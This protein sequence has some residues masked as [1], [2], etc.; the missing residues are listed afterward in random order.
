MTATVDGLTL[1]FDDPHL[2]PTAKAA[3]TAQQR[4][5]VRLTGP[6][7]KRAATVFLGGDHRLYDGVRTVLSPGSMTVVLSHTGLSDLAR[8]IALGRLRGHRVDV[9]YVDASRE[10]RLSLVPPPGPGRPDD[11][12]GRVPRPRQPSDLPPVILDGDDALVE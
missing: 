5:V 1:Q 11:V 8:V 2:L 6:S 12:Q 9:E 10:F 3:L 4:V 7:A